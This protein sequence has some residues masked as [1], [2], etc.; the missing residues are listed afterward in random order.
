MTVREWLVNLRDKFKD[1]KVRIKNQASIMVFQR[2][3]I[4]NWR[5]KQKIDRNLRERKYLR[6][7]YGKIFITI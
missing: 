5:R 3:I 4:C 1:C 7:K 2:R 6:L